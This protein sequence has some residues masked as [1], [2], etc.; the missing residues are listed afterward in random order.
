[1]TISALWVN[2]EKMTMQVNI[3]GV[4]MYVVRT[5]DGDLQGQDPEFV[6]KVADWLKA[7]NE[8]SPG[9]FGD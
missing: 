3:D 2:P 4:A 6:Q 9:N 1:M 8:P 7:G 5:V